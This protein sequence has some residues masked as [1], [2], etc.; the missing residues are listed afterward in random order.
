MKFFCKALLREPG[1]SFINAIA[2]DEKHS[3]PDYQKA[4]DEF[5]V[6]A[7]TLKNLGVTPTI[8]PADESFPDGNFVEDPYFVL[9]DKLIIELNPGTASRKDEYTSLQS[10]L[11][12]HLPVYKISKEFT[13][14]G[15]DI[16]KDGKN[17][18]IGLSKRTQQNA[19]DAFNNI[20][21]PHGY[22][23]HALPVP[24]GLHL[25]SGMTRVTH[26]NYVIQQ[27]F[28]SILKT[29]QRDDPTI[30][31]FIVPKEENHAANVLAI[32]G[33]IIIPDSCPETRKY[34]RQYYS[35]EKIHE[36][37][38]EQVRLVDGALTCSSLLFKN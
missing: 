27:P 20:V 36:V 3:K 29:M 2:Q 7:K 10:Y 5:L 26:K 28:E 11:P 22:Q 24:E 34:I 18:Y 12:K 14:D 8:C 23:V 37:S 30:K 35:D 25:K 15:G 1:K 32:N 31:Y 16:L 21:S 6:Y 19:I 13:I 33:Q 17:I 38:T 4:R 9:S